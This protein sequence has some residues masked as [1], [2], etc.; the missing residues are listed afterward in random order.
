MCKTNKS[1][2]TRGR[3]LIKY[4]TEISGMKFQSAGGSGPINH[5]QSH[6]EAGVTAIAHVRNEGK[7]FQIIQLHLKRILGL[8]KH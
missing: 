4:S 3:L 8:K 5:A 1:T 2:Y 7:I 6:V